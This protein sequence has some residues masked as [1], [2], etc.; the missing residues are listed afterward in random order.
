MTPSS[1]LQERLRRYLL[2]QLTAAEQEEIEKEL[3]ANGD[4]FEELLVI[5]DEIIDEYLHGEFSPTDVAAFETQFLSTPERYNQLKFG[6]I[7]QT[8]LLQNKP[9]AAPEF[10]RAPK[11]SGWMQFPFSSPWRLA[12]VAIV[13]VGIALGTWQLFFRQ[14]EVDKGLIALNAAYREQRPTESRISN[15]DYAPFIVTRGSEAGKADENEL[16]RAELTLLDALT[17][18]PTPTAYHA[19]G[20]VYLAKKDFDKAIENFDKALQAD[21]KNAKLLSDLGASWL[22]KGKFEQNET[23]PGQN[24]E[25]YARSLEYI[26]RALEVNPNLL[27]ALFNRGLVHQL[28]MLPEQAA[29]DW[30]S[31]LEKDPNSKWA[32]EARQ[33]LRSLEEQK[34]K[35]SQ[36]KEKLLQDFLRAHNSHDDDSAWHVISISRDAISRTMIWEQLLDRYLQASTAGRADDARHDL[37][38]LAYEGELE[39]RRADDR[40]VIDL[41]RFYQSASERQ[42]VNLA[43]ARELMKQGHE[44]YLKGDLDKATDSYANAKRMFVGIGDQSESK[45]ASYWIG[46][47][48]VQVG[49]TQE[50]LSILENLVLSLQKENYQWLLMRSLYVASTAC[51]NLDEYSKAINYNRRALSVAERIN[52]VIGIF[53]ASNVLIFQ[54]VS[55]GNHTQALGYVRRS[56]SVINECPLNG[57]QSGRYYSIVAVAFDDAG[58]SYAAIDYEK[59]A[60]KRAIEINLAQNISA[61]YA[62]LGVMYARVGKFENAFRSLDLAYTAAKSCPDEA[63]RKEMIGF[64]SLETGHLYREQGQFAKAISYY[65]QTISVGENLRFQNTLYEAHKNRLFC[66]LALK[67]DRAA[68]EE[69]RNTMGLAEKYRSTIVEVDNRNGFFDIQQNVYDLAIDFAYSREDDP[70]TAFRYS[71]DSRSRSLLDSVIGQARISDKQAPDVSFASVTQPLSLADIQRRLPANAQILQYAVLTDRVLIWIVSN[72]QFTAVDTRI[73]QRE[74]EKAVNEYLQFIAAPT[75]RPEEIQSRAKGLYEILIQPAESLLDRKKTI[76]LVPDKFLTAVPFGTLISP[77]SG[78]YLLEDY[79]LE[80][81]PSASL[82][83]ILSEMAHK[84]DGPREERVLSIGNPRFDRDAFPTLADLPA[85]GREA[86]QVAACYSSS[87]VFTGIDATRQAVNSEMPN[88][89]VIHFAS[90]SVAD[91]VS[92]MQSKLVLAKDRAVADSSQRSDGSMRAYEIYRLKLVHT[93]LAVLS[94]C[95]TGAERYYRG[96]GMIS[97][98]RPFLAAG[99]PLVVVSLWA[100]DSDASAKLMISF[101]QHRKRENLSSAEAL[102]QAQLDMLKKPDERLHG[103]SCWGA[104]ELIGG[105]TT[106]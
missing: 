38:A 14:S 64:S 78:R 40:Y 68:A 1:D 99:V 83:V 85:A 33:N 29:E 90:H 8:F 60:L 77:T 21:P 88:A 47:C 5:E 76:N 19:L 74:L 10:M 97:L 75:P 105:S 62:R 17:H 84:K 94:A 37:K 104:F 49:K 35:T 7:F 25:D 70:Q 73:S 101:H 16:R 67:D 55:A 26:S 57:T 71:E 102:R 48:D 23:K 51:H 100:V 39:D 89:D 86:E 9:I 31:Y 103:I 93:R 45:Y 30:R 46:N 52:D 53:D 6:R 54:Y 50:G 58:L 87:R 24:F 32:D 4:L 43:Q 91:E 22:E 41:T 3:I 12:A 15:F 44:A 20:K 81:S 56:L 36:T 96:E 95:H 66:Y 82:L 69:L 98:A 92:P 2:G 65:D 27:E 42:K 13:I 80:T 11:R 63:T 28:L 106:Y 18:N 59:E 34:L 79:L 72:T 61:R